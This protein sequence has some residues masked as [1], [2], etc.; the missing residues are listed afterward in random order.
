MAFLAGTATEGAIKP[1]APFAVTDKFIFIYKIFKLKGPGA[2]ALQR[3]RA[4]ESSALWPPASRIFSTR[5]DKTSKRGGHRRSR[6]GKAF[7]YHPRRRHSELKAASF[8]RVRKFSQSAE[9][10][11][12]DHLTRPSQQIIIANGGKQGWW[13]VQTPLLATAKMPATE[14]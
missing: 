7:E 6:E 8:L 13:A 14:V 1:S 2:A 4:A 9:G 10:T 11:R 5:P 12:L 3:R